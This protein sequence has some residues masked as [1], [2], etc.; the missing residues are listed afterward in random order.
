MT[1]RRA[2]PIEEA[3]IKALA[4]EM[5]QAMPEGA[6]LAPRFVEALLYLCACTAKAQGIA[7]SQL[8]MALVE[9]IDREWN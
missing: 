5:L 8:A 9:A 3:E 4:L 1:I 7:R 2:S 6:T